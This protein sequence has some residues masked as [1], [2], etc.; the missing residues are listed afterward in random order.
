MARIRKLSCLSMSRAKYNDLLQRYPDKR[1]PKPLSVER[2]SA[3]YRLCVIKS[4][5]TN[6]R[7]PR[8]ALIDQQELTVVR[9]AR[10]DPV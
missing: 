5:Q 7:R 4:G 2:M 9:V 3:K 8:D 1:S 10:R 6:E